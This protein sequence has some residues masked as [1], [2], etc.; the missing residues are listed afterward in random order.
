MVDA[1]FRWMGQ[2]KRV[3]LVTAS[4]DEADA[5]NQSIQQRRIDIGQLSTRKIALGRA[6]PWRSPS[7]WSRDCVRVIRRSYS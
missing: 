6:C 1:W 3:A 2:R 4:N 5:V 7:Q